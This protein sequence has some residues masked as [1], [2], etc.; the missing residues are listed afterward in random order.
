MSDKAAAVERDVKK[1]NSTSSKVQGIIHILAL[2]L[3]IYFAAPQYIQSQN[4][5]S[6]NT[7]PFNTFD[8]FYPF[9]ISQHADETCR[10][11]HF[12]GT[13][14]IIF[15][16][17]TR[18]TGVFPSLLLSSLVG[19]VTFLATKHI[20]HG[21]I[22][23]AVMFGTFIFA[24]SKYSCWKRGV[25]ILL[26]A[27][28]FAWVGHFVFEHNRPATFVYPLFSLMGDFKLW[29]EIFSRQRAF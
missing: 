3:G 1:K 9:Y 21:F 11:L 10:R 7:K 19:S 22:E 29:F 28:S 8:E 26:V 2:A 20:D 12:I 6:A 13:S 5:V 15:Y 27:Y 25:A 18:D 16:A 23:M 17:F 14:L 4:L 24:M